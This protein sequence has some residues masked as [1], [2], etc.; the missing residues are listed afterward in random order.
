[1][2]GKGVKRTVVLEH[3]V[4]DAKRC[5]ALV[6]PYDATLIAAAK[7]A[8]AKWSASHK[9]WYV[10][11]APEHIRAIFAAFKGVAWVDMNGLSKK[12]DAAPPGSETPALQPSMGNT[13]GKKA[14]PAVP[15]AAHASRKEAPSLNT[16]QV[17]ALAAMRRK[18]EV[19]RYSPRSI[20]V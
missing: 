17:E 18:L 10:P 11:N 19:A 9:C 13:K 6:F 4:H 14:S 5:I 3:L 7:Q 15:D 20:Q 8:G 1:M 2:D 16:D 12:P